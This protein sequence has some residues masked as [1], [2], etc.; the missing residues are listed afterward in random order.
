MSPEIAALEEDL[1]DIERS[2]AL[3]AAEIELELAESVL[4]DPDSGDDESA[5]GGAS[6]ADPRRRYAPAG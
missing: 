2:A 3:L 4:R 1:T 6:P 5:P